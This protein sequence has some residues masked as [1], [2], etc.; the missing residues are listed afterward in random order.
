MIPT[1]FTRASE[2]RAWRST[3]PSN[4][5]LAFVPTMGALHQGHVALMKQARSM[6]DKV[7][8]SIFVN[9]LQF[10][11]K[12]DLANYPRPFDADLQICRKQGIDAV[13]APTIEEVHPT[14]SNTSISSGQLGDLYEGEHRRGHFDGVLTVVDRLFEIVTPHES[15]FGQKDFQQLVLIRQMC[16]E[17]HPS[18][19]IASVPTVRDEDGLAISSR[20]TRLTPADRKLATKLFESLCA[21][22]SCF[23]AGVTNPRQLELTGRSTLNIFPDISV[24]YLVCVNIAN[25][26]AIEVVDSPA[27]VLLAATI[28]SVRLIDNIEL[29]P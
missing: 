2:V 8:V 1:L 17:R 19:R 20:N 25:L 15:I 14:T 13:F 11:D 18:T 5:T 6:A 9:P 23:Q 7:I 12:D 16:A 3:L 22:E 4:S 29:I 10:D 28:G 21:I 27:I 24:D 26:A